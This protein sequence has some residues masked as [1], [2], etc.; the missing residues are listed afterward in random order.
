[1]PCTVIY[2]IVS[3]SFM[4]L[5]VKPTVLYQTTVYTNARRFQNALKIFWCTYL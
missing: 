4:Q 2:K 5:S 1:M 3:L